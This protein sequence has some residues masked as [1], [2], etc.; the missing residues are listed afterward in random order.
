[1]AQEQ[2]MAAKPGQRE[3]RKW[4]LWI[5]QD[6]GPEMKKGHV[7]NFRNKGHVDD[8][9][10][11]QQTVKKLRNHRRRATPLTRESRSCRIKY[12]RYAQS[13]TG[14]HP[15]QCYQSLFVLL[16]CPLEY[17]GERHATVETVGDQN[18]S[19]LLQEEH[20]AKVCTD[21]IAPQPCRLGK[22]RFDCNDVVR[23]KP[24]FLT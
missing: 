18:F 6:V 4:D 20:V 23:L 8:P 15:A 7:L 14:R 19:K 21:M 3:L 12:F 10:G 24:R 11:R 13:D 2:L 1:M 9:T 16:D 22:I 17:K 5:E